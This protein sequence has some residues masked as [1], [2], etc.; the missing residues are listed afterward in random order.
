MSAP[1]ELVKGN[2]SVLI[3]SCL[4]REPMHGYRIVRELERM[5]EGYFAMREGT[6]YPHLH[7]L[8][9]DGLVEGCWETV[10]GGRERKM[11][12]ITDKG[13]AELARKTQEWETFQA[14]VD[15]VLKLRPEGSGA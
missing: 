4:A 15:R 2:A 14:N 10:T 3:L 13:M 1:T 11:Y 6:L 5:S 8:E 12:R 9:K 7:Q